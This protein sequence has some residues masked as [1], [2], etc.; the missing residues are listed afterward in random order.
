MTHITR[1]LSYFLAAVAFTT[2]FATARV[3]IAE[4]IEVTPGTCLAC[5]PSFDSS[6]VIFKNELTRALN[7]RESPDGDE[8]LQATLRIVELIESGNMHEARRLAYSEPLHSFTSNSHALRSPALAA[9]LGV[10]GLLDQNDLKV[11]LAAKTFSQAIAVTKSAAESPPSLRLALQNL[12]ADCQSRQ[13][14]I[15]QA[16]ELLRHAV[17]LPDVPDAVSPQVA[18]QTFLNLA[19]SSSRAG[20]FATANDALS[21]AIALGRR[22]KEIADAATFAEARVRGEIAL[23]QF[24]FQDAF[25]EFRLAIGDGMRSAALPCEARH[26]DAMLLAA[27]SEILCKAWTPDSKCNCAHAADTIEGVKRCLALGLGDN[28]ELDVRL[29]IASARVSLAAGDCESS[30]RYVEAAHQVLSKLPEEL[31]LLRANLLM[32]AGNALYSEGEHELALQA[33]TDAS[34]LLSGTEYN[35]TLAECLIQRGDY[36]L[37]SDRP[38]E[39]L[40]MQLDASDKLPD[41][42]HALNNVIA[43][44]VAAIAARKAARKGELTIATQALSAAEANLKRD[45]GEFNLFGIAAKV[46]HSEC[47][48]V[49]GDAAKGKEGLE[50]AMRSMEASGQAGSALYKYARDQFMKLP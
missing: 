17:N 6:L 13:G 15:W 32:T 18:L 1:F 29:L 27:E 48:V 35:I 10:R 20:D 50:D 23:Q 42:T 41:K 46:Y 40:K 38:D 26:I 2:W 28:L 31:P 16:T 3:V 8:S 4:T 11:T 25:H 9:I 33:A 12:L 19:V 21:K 39:S 5:T 36:L 14:K 47:L 43:V 30:L 37:A 34:R 44:N 22:Y 49:S 24:R 7:S 45:Y